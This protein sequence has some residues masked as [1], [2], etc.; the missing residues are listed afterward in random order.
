MTVKLGTMQLPVT[1]DADRVRDYL[2]GTIADGGLWTALGRAS[3]HDHTGGNNGK[4]I[5]IASIPDGSIP[6]SKLDPAVLAPYALVDGSKPF[7]GQQAF[8]A[9][10]LVRDTLWFGAKP[11][12]AAD[13]SLKRTAANVLEAAG[14]FSV[15]NPAGEAALRLYAP[16]DQWKS[17]QFQRDSGSTARWLLGSSPT[18][19]NFALHCYD[20]AGAYVGQ[21]FA[22]NRTDRRFQPDTGIR[23]APGVSIDFGGG[24]WALSDGVGNF[25]YN[26]G[27]AHMWNGPGWPSAL[28]LVSGVL[29]PSVN[30]ALDLGTGG[31]RFKSSFVDNAYATGSYQAGYGSAVYSHYQAAGVWGNGG[32]FNINSTNSVVLSPSNGADGGY[33]HPAANAQTYLGHP[34]IRFKYVFGRVGDFDGDLVTTG[35]LKSSGV[36]YVRAGSD[37]GNYCDYVYSG[38]YSTWPAGFTFRGSSDYLFDSNGPGIM[39][40]L[41]NKILDIH[42]DLH[43]GPSLGQNTQRWSALWTTAGAINTSTVEYKENIVPLDPETF[44]AAFRRTTFWKFD[45]R[46]GEG[47]PTEG[48]VGRHGVVLRSPDH[49]ADPL[50]ALPDGE[51]SEPN[52]Y[53][54]GIAMALRG[55]MEETEERL[56]MLEERLRA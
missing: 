6:P 30:A 38:I 47:W 27:S 29:Y 53:A 10:L 22:I 16:D 42:P 46:R 31:N 45:Y 36:G 14:Q 56:R 43:G 51:S 26:A 25:Q 44:L 11:A 12:G 2:N 5:S 17:I 3:D 21:A 49:P 1:E 33:I 4:P 35:Y 24:S 19:N 52:H 54:T 13:A 28:Y 9:D 40:R 15:R 39:I 37:G 20:D 7:T 32:N 23:L 50:F 18:Q 48:H 41:T 55:Y 8:N 34:G